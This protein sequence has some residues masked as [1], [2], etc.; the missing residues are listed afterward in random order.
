MTIAPGFLSAPILDQQ[1]N[2]ENLAVLGA[3]GVSYAG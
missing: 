1:K 3:I 2:P